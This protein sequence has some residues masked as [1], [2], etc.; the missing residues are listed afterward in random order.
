MGDLELPA[1]EIYEEAALL[2]Q[3]LREHSRDEG[4]EFITTTHSKMQEVGALSFCQS[5]AGA[6]I[7][8]HKLIF[9]QV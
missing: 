4:T 6:Q 5:A 9:I 1:K 8:P 3:L 2:I 7:H